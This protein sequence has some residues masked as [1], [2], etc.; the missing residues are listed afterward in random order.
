MA[1]HAAT[2]AWSRTIGWRQGHILPDE[3]VTALGLA[4]GADALVMVISHDCDLANENLDIEPF[5][6]VI[7][8][9]RLTAPDPNLADL[10]SPRTL[11]LA[12]TCVELRRTFCLLAC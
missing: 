4:S 8:G 3:A 6:E 10:K 12:I 11:H 9:K 5:V 2:P 1:K 7:A